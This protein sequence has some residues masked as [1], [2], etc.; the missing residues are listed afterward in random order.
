MIGFVIDWIRIAAPHARRIVSVCNGAFLAAEAGLLDGCSATTHW[1]SADQ[2]AREF[3]RIAV[4]AD[5]IFVRSSEQMWTAAGVTAGIDLALALVE[6]DYGTDVAQNVARWLVLYLRRPGGQTQFAPPVWMP[7]AKREPIRD[8]DVVRLSA[9]DG[10]LEVLVDSSD[11]E[12]RDEAA[13]P[14]PAFGT[15]RE[16]FAFMRQGADGAEQGA[17]AMLAAAGL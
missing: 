2:L 16:L 6:D 8:G 4:D 9:E 13:A 14:P 11:W 17:S 3:P 10:S 12:A 1:A 15:G 7:R 5:P